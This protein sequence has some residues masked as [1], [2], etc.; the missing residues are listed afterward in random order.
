M[1]PRR[2]YKQVQNPIADAKRLAIVLDGSEISFGEEKQ[3]QRK[4]LSLVASVANLRKHEQNCLVIITGMN[5]KQEATKEQRLS[6]ATT[7]MDQSFLSQAMENGFSRRAIPL[8]QLYSDDWETTMPQAAPLITGPTKKN[9]RKS[10]QLVVYASTRSASSTE[11]RGPEESTIARL[12]QWWKADLIV[13][14]GGEKIPYQDDPEQ[15]AGNRIIHRYTEDLQWVTVAR[16][17]PLGKSQSTLYRALGIA[18]RCVALHIPIFFSTD[19]SLRSLA[20]LSWGKA[21]GM[22]L[23]PG[24]RLLGMCSDFVLTRPSLSFPMFS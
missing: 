10:Q 16:G 9:R 6:S 24:R 19:G 18:Q 17:T 7:T 3:I 8:L 14:L 23:L 21:R 5:K 20:R 4:V 11:M 2:A 1:L 12:V 22:V 13:F 15:V